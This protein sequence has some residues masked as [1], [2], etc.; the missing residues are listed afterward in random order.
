V[1]LTKR[2]HAI[3]AWCSQCGEQRQMIHPEEA[4]AR[5][6]VGLRAIYRLVKRISS[7][8]SRRLKDWFSSVSTQLLRLGISMKE[9]QCD[10][11]HDRSD[12]LGPLQSERRCSRRRESNS[13]RGHSNERKTVKPGKVRS[14][15][16]LVSLFGLF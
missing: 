6:G 10:A 11:G 14:P 4:A 12:R 8:S 3:E 15:L 9:A 13:K 7:I 2:V 16:L 1:S 5:A